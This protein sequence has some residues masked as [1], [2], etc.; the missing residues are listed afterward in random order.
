MEK[1]IEASRGKDAKNGGMNVKDIKIYLISLQ[2]PSDEFT[3]KNINKSKRAELNK[4][5]TISLNDSKISPSIRQIAPLVSS[6]AKIIT[7]RSKSLTQAKTIKVPEGYKK[8]NVLSWHKKDTKYYELSPY[9]LKTDEGVL[10]ENLWQFSKVYPSSE[11]IK[12]KPHYSSKAIWWE[13]DKK[14]IMYDAKTEQ[15]TQE[16]F[17]W[18]QSGFDC[19]NPI[20]YPV[21]RHNRHKCLFSRETI[22]GLEVRYDYI[23]ARKHIY[24]KQ[25]IYLIR[26]LP[27]Y[28]ELLQDLKN[29]INLCITEVDLPSS[30]KK[31]TFNL[32]DEN[33]IYTASIETLLM[34]LN[35]PSEA[36][37]HGLVLIYSLLRDLE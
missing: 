4:L 22:D 33:E 8:I 18:Q 20:R 35:D 16:Y 32:V 12:V 14:E 31:G 19:P 28:M 25:Y 36:Y 30:T 10:F 21:G 26:K 13:Y 11:I 37:G 1:V 6:D 29:G 9:H 23:E 17:D 24:F 3:K 27:I 5:L 7:I 15:V 34:M 2:L